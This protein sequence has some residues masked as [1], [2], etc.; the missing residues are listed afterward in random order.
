MD[1]DAEDY[2]EQQMTRSDI[3]ALIREDTID[4]DLIVVKALLEIAVERTDTIKN[5]RTLVYDCS[6]AL[7]S[8]AEL[9]S[10]L[11]VSDAI[12]E[13]ISLAAASL[14]R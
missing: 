3:S 9:L 14:Q 8:I 13:G 2:E 10:R 12:A 11:D 6:F 1:S 4:S 7:E 5:A